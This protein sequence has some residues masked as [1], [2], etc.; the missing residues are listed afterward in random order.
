VA[1]LTI[2]DAARACRVARSTLQRAVN[3]GRLSLDPE[4]RI[5]TAEL[6]RAGYTLHAARQGDDCC[7]RQGVLQD[8]APRSSSTRQDAAGAGPSDATLMQQMLATL[9]RENALLRAALDAA[10]A[11]EEEARANAQAAREERTLLLHMLQE[12]QHRYDRLLD[13]PRPAP[14]EA[15]QDAPGATP[16]R[17]RPQSPPCPR[18]R[19]R[20]NQRPREGILGATCAGALWR[21]CA[22]ILKASRLAR[23]GPCSTPTRAWRIR[24]WGGCA[25]GSS[26]V[27]GEGGMWQPTHH[28]TIDDAKIRHDY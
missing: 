22:S 6:L 7:T 16:A 26:S 4:H 14:Q 8:A 3:A 11:R 2:S 9:E 19:P 23:C 1:K 15:P 24:A 13:M 28:G 20:G 10:A 27:W 5:D 17:R 21:S 12:M 18:D 25:M